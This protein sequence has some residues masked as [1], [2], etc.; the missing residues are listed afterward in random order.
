M[1]THVILTQ[2]RENII[3]YR[4]IQHLLVGIF[5]IASVAFS[6]IYAQATSNAEISVKG[7]VSDEYGPLTGVNIA[8]LGSNDGAITDTDGTFIFPKSLQPNDIL[9]FSYLGYETRRIKIKAD[10][11]FL[12]IKMVSEAIDIVGALAV[13]KPYKSKRLF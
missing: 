9:V 1:K 7:M 3:S 11:N 4:M 2:K 8:L 10:T 6:S 5:M 13:D 12:N